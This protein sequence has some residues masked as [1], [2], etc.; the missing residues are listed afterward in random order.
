M[1][2]HFCQ[3]SAPSLPRP[4][5]SAF[6]LAASGQVW[7]LNWKTNT[8]ELQKQWK[9]KSSFKKICMLYLFLVCLF[10]LQSLTQ[11]DDHKMTYKCPLLSCKDHT[12]KDVH[13]QQSPSL[14]LSTFIR[15]VASPPL[16]QG[17][18]ILNVPRNKNRSRNYGIIELLETELFILF[19]FLLEIKLQIPSMH[20]FK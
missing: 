20:R 2:A 4:H 15:I 10:I 19:G 5:L 6:C 17:A 1:S 3:F 9:N 14:P 8:E 7:T 13:L 16:P 12:D 18:E 11:E